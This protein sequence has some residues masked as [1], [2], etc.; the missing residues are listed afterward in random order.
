M[1]KKYERYISYILNDIKPPYFKNMIDNYGLSPNEYELV[2]SK[3][4][5]K[6]I[7]IKGRNVYDTNNNL[8]YHEYSNGYWIKYVYDNNGNRIYSEGSDGYWFKAEYDDN[9]NLMYYENSTGEI[10][11]YR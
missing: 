1:N 11:D 2:L 4:Y 5:N 8:I 7:T 3:V 9:G 6:S 10:E